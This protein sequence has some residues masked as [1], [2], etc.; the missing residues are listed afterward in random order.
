MKSTETLE[1]W[2]QAGAELAQPK[3]DP[4]VML[5][6]GELEKLSRTEEDGWITIR[7]TA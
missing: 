2:V 4:L 5:P 7:E 6:N 1:R 3:G